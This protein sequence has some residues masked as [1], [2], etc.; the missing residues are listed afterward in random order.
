MNETDK[1]LNTATV[2]GIVPSLKTKRERARDKVIALSQ[3]L[4]QAKQSEAHLDRKEG[5]IGLR[6]LEDK[7]QEEARLAEVA[8]VLGDIAHD[9]KNMLMPI[10][11]GASLLEEKLKESF[12]RLTQPVDGPVI[13]SRELTKELIDMIQNGSR[14][15]Q[16]WVGEFADS[17]KGH[18]R[19][20]QFAPC[21]IAEVVTQHGRRNNSR[22]RT[23]RRDLVPSHVTRAGKTNPVSLHKLGLSIRS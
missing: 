11:S 22:K 14:R 1:T 5:E 17:I 13:R 7:V 12:A 16:R 9:I 3:A 2:R 4:A 15:I 21:H 20:P 10:I 8:R 18:A 23:R 19:S 6:Q